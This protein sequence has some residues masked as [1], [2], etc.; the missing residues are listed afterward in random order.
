MF[1]TGKGIAEFMP[2]TSGRHQDCFEDHVDVGDLPVKN[3]G[4]MVCDARHPTF[5]A[6]VDITCCMHAGARA[7]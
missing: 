6:R 7:F 5:S 3:Q 1:R 4:V 2:L